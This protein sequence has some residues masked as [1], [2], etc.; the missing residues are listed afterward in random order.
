MKKKISK[1]DVENTE[2]TLALL[3]ILNPML[4]VNESRFSNASDEVIIKK[5]QASYV[6]GCWFSVIN[7]AE[8]YIYG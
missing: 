6:P 8:R 1:F 5:L 4:R 2:D 3:E 7:F